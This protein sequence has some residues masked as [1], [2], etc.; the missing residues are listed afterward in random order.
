MSEEGVREYLSDEELINELI[1]EPLVQAVIKGVSEEASRIAKGVKELHSLRIRIRDK[2]LRLGMLKKVQEVSVRPKYAALDTGYT[3]PPIELIGGR[4]LIVIR[5]HIFNFNAPEE[6]GRAGSVGF[7][8]FV[9]DENVGKPLSKIIEREF[10]KEVLI[11]KADGKLNIDLIILDGELFPR[12]PPGYVAGGRGGI[13]RKLYGRILELTDE[14]LSLANETDTALAGVV[15][16][17]YGRDIPVVIGEPGIRVNDKALSTYILEPGEWVSIETYSDLI[18][19]LN[20]FI[21]EFS[22]SLTSRCRRA[23]INRLRWISA[24]VRSCSNT[25]S[26]RIATYKAMLPTYFAA[27]TKVELWPSNDLVLE[28]LIAYLSSIT[29]VNG[30]PHPI[31]IVDSMCRLRREVLHLTQQRLQSELTRLLG[32]D[33]LAVSIAGLTNPE[34]MY[35]IGFK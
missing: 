23:L 1:E 14:V 29:G 15:K 5:S 32:D 33:R 22:D 16:R 20:T 25:S 30:V 8:R 4:L 26:I 21:K 27:A 3:S 28:D 24:V 17:V 11:L 13:I 18:H 9:E 7:I 6:V 10:I 2:L 12:I 35:R 19:R 31:D 34:K